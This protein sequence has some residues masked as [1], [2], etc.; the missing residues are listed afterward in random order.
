MS[1]RLVVFFG[2]PSVLLFALA[3]WLDSELLIWLA[4]IGVMV[5]GIVFAFDQM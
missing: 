5:A 3:H 1:F 2:V 4:M